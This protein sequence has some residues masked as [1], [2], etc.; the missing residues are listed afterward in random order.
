[1]TLVCVGSWVTATVAKATARRPDLLSA[2][3]AALSFQRKGRAAPNTH[4]DSGGPAPQSR[5]AVPGN[6]VPAGPDTRSF[7]APWPFKVRRA[8]LRKRKGPVWHGSQAG[9]VVGRFLLRG[10]LRRGSGGPRDDASAS[11]PFQLRQP[12]LISFVPRPTAAAWPAA[13][14]RTMKAGAAGVPSKRLDAGAAA[15]DTRGG[16]GV[17]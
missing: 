5:A 4:A 7:P 2:A 1:M 11:S 12:R 9:R 16:L 10:A 14:R 3:G 15:Q 8:H 6:G 17:Q 13:T